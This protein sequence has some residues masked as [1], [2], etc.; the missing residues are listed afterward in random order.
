MGCCG[1]DLTEEETE[2]RR[3]RSKGDFTTGEVKKFVTFFRRMAV[4]RIQW[5]HAVSGRVHAHTTF[6]PLEAGLTKLDARENLLKYFPASAK[7]LK[8][9]REIDLSQNN[10]KRFPGQAFAAP[11][12]RILRLSANKVRNVR[13]PSNL[14]WW[15][16]PCLPQALSSAPLKP[17]SSVKRGAGVC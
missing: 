7:R 6:Q 1:K 13:L 3:A 16:A 17:V 9:C 4:V 5:T 2:L 8:R 14:R 15:V 12:L 11:N 10:F